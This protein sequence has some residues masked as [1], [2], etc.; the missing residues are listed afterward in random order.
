M[1]SQTP[2]EK[3]K[4]NTKDREITIRLNKYIKKELKEE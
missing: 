4:R 3:S 2:K 1:K